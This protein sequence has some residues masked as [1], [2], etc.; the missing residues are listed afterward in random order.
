MIAQIAVG[1]RNRLGVHIA[2]HRLVVPAHRKRRRVGV[3]PGQRGHWHPKRPAR[4]QREASK[5]RRHI[6]GV[7]P[8]QRS[9]QAVVVEISGAETWPQQVLD[10]LVR[11]ELRHQ[12]QLPIA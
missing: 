12:I 7:Q 11:E 8:V 6:V 4:P 10:R 5:Q 9:P 2:F 3:Q 1:H